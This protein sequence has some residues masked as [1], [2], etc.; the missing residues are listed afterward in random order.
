VTAELRDGVL[1][2]DLPKRVS[3][4]TRRIRAERR[5]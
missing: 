1:R 2:I 3:S 5:T 4:A